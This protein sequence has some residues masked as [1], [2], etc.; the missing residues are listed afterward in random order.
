MVTQDILADP[1]RDSLNP[2][3]RY[4]LESDS[5]DEIGGGVYGST[6]ISKTS[7]SQRPPATFKLNPDIDDLTGRHTFI[8]IGTAGSEFGRTLSNLRDSQGASIET[9]D[10]QIGTAYPISTS[11]LYIHISSKIPTTLLWPLSRWLLERFKPTR[12]VLA[13]IDIYPA[14][15]YITSSSVPHPSLPIR[16][17]ET[18]TPGL[19]QNP[20]QRKRSGAIEPF[21]PPN[22]LGTQ[23]LASALIPCTQASL[24]SGNTSLKEEAILVLLPWPKMSVPA[25]KTLDDGALREGLASPE[26]NIW[27]VEELAATADAIGIE[28][29]SSGSQE[30]ASQQRKKRMTAAQDGM[31]I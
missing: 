30:R 23:T 18:S 26:T 1:L 2:P 16:Y 9:G 31:Y 7:P 27:R 4:Q 25:P 10:Y 11:Q 28:G 22:L 8:A 29:V 20:T 14:P 13:I 19:A 3:P 21:S 15:A 6:K 24:F 17:L 12:Q 5:E